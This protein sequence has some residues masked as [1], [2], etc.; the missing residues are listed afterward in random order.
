MS[1]ASEFHERVKIWAQGLASALLLAR[2]MLLVTR[3]SSLVT[4]LRPD[5]HRH[6]R[7]QRQ[8]QV[9]D[10]PWQ[11]GLQRQSIRRDGQWLDGRHHRYRCDYH[12]SGGGRIQHLF[13]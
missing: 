6:A 13:G 1:K 2:S 10:R 12:G 8:R 7:F 4:A 9:G 11:P 5:A 3:H